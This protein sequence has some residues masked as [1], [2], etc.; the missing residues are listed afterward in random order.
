METMKILY[1]T[2]SFQHTSLGDH[3]RCYDFIKELSRGH[4]IALLSATLLRDLVERARLVR[5]WRQFVQRNHVW[6]RGGE[7]LERMCNE[8]VAQAHSREHLAAE[9]SGSIR[10]GKHAEET[11]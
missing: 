8:A 7:T 3:T 2:S 4:E 5:E 1:L 11:Q 10:Q 6:S 9:S